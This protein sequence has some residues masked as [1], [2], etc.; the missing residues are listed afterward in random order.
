MKDLFDSQAKLLQIYGQRT[1]HPGEYDR[2]IY[3]VR[4]NL[5]EEEHGDLQ[6]AMINL[7]FECKEPSPLINEARA[8]FLKE[9]S[10]LLVVLFGTAVQLGFTLDEL[11]SAFEIVDMDNQ[12]KAYANE[13]S[14]KDALEYYK[15]KDPNHY[16][17]EITLG[18]PPVQ[19]KAYI[20]KNPAGKV[21][22]RYPQPQI[23][24]EKRILY[25][26]IAEQNKEV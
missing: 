3:A 15:A 12:S 2:H 20:V 6:M 13:A 7:A 26:C 24:V 17:Q 9:F 10:D 4:Q 14:A 19:I 22:K 11:S 16:I 18:T 1:L 21:M 25:H 23:D 5:I 8:H